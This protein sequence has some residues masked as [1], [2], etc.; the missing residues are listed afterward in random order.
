MPLGPKVLALCLIGV[1][2]S[3][4]TTVSAKSPPPGKDTVLNTL[5]TELT[6]SQKNLQKRGEE[7]LFY[8][9][10]RLN[11]GRWFQ[12]SA[13]YGALLEVSDPRDPV[14]GRSRQLD[15]SARV[16]S[17]A[18]DNTHKVRGGFDFDLDRMFGSASTLPIEDDPGAL[19]VGIW[20]ATDRAYKNAVKQLIK[21]KGNRAVKVEEDDR[22]DDFSKEKPHT[23]VA[24]EVNIELDRALWKD[25]LKRLSALFKA[26]PRILNSSINLQGGTTNQYFV[27][28]EGT[29]LRQSHFFARVMLWGTVKADDG[30]DLELYDDLEAS[31]VD[32]LPTDQQLT[33]RVASLINRLEALR[34][35]PVVEPY[36]G[37]AIMTNRAAAVFFHEIFGHRVEGHRNK[38]ADE[39][40][41]FTKRL[42]QGVV[43]DFISVT[44][45]PTRQRYG[46]VPLNGYY[47]YDDE[48]VPAQKVA[49]VDHG[50]LKAFLLGRSPITGFPHSNGHGRAQPGLPPV[51]RQGNLLVESSKQVPYD[52]LR[53]ELIDEV[54]RQKKPYGL[55]FQDISGGF[56][57]T[58]TGGNPQAFKILPLVVMRVYAD[59]RPDELVRGVDVVGTPLASF[60]RIMA[61]GDDFAVFNGYCGAESG[62]VPVSAIAP[63][64]LIR[65]IEV[66]RKEVNQ[67]KL[68]LLAAPPLVPK[69]PVTAEVSR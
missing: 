35:A 7:P 30:M 45:D 19:Q 53:R 38:D 42:N 64:I 48:G 11:D 41:T 8:L 14:L 59:G 47:T 31:T 16:G 20:K 57:N 10:Y 52:Q 55:V 65:D 23:D 50:V 29:R 37:P 1:A 49:L 15:V 24:A 25:R 58:R 21:V 46:T 22:A 68:P 67:D 61:T 39:G 63:S 9:S 2:A 43:P 62:F 32:A 66:E 3:A 34:T 33:D 5:V 60:E 13:S 36:S 44:D 12:E 56:T 6:R 28:T 27:D 26:H 69:R 54:K 4:A 51:A 18:L 40:H 17:P